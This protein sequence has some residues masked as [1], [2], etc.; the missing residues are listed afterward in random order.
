M[1]DRVVHD[2]AANPGEPRKV[3]IFCPGCHCGHGLDLKPEGRWTFNEN[4]DKPTFSPS[5]NHPDSTGCH[6]H[7][8]DGVMV[9]T[10]DSKVC[11][12]QSLPLEPF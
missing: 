8:T 7:I 5:L 1:N 4:Y 10:D 6:S 12:G 9:F 3:M 2:L 11:P